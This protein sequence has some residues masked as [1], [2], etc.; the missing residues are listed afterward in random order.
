MTKPLK[1]KAFRLHSPT[2]LMGF[3]E[4]VDYADKKKFPG[5]IMDLHDYGL[6]ITANNGITSLVPWASVK[7]I[8]VDTPENEIRAKT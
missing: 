3:G 4:S 1:V 8:V 6:V 2:K 7:M 5:T